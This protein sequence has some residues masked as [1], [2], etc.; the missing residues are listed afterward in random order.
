MAFLRNAQ[1]RSLIGGSLLAVGLVLLAAAGAYYAYV[2]FIAT[3]GSDELTVAP[4]DDRSETLHGLSGAGAITNRPSP[5]WQELYPG[6]LLPARQWADPRGSLDLKIPALGGFTPVSASGRASISGEIGRA[7][8]ISIPALDLEAGVD[9]LEIND[10]G[11]ASS[12]VTPKNTVGH[13]PSSPNP[14]SHGNGWYF[15]HLESPIAGEGNVFSRLPRVPELLRQ[16]NDVHVIIESKGR[17]YLYLVSQTDLIHEDEIELYQASD[18]RVTLV[19]CFP[20]LR[21][22]QRLLVTAQLIGFR[23]LLS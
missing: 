13:I 4:L 20:R 22:D 23:D 6:T 17:E 8:R 10:L 21:Y 16:G 7:E 9:E 14:G 19:T 18:A 2:T 15:G 5:A 11:N 3:H 12:Y 1:P